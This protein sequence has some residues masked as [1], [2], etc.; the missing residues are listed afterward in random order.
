MASLVLPGGASTAAEFQDRLF[1]EHGIEV[2]VIPFEGQQLLRISMQCYNTISDVERLAAALPLL[3]L[4]A[5]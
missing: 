4:S 5:D 1:L 3:L 2:P